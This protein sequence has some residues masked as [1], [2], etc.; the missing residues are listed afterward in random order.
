MTEASA[1]APSTGWLGTFERRAPLVAALV[2]L[3]AGIMTMTSD[4]IGVFNDDGIYLLTAKALAEGNGYVYPHLPG[5]PP[6]IHYPPVW[7]ML[8]A[9][10]WKIAPD[11]PAN[12]GWFKLINP[13]FIAAAAAGAVT[14]GQRLL[15][16]RWWVALL[17]A[18]AATL[19]V[20]VLLLTNLLLSEP[21][22]L[23]ML[24][25]TLWVTERLVREGGARL[26]FGAAALIAFLVLVRT[27]GGVV[28]VAGVLLLA[29]ERRWKELAILAVTTVALLMPWQIFVWRAIPTFPDELLG[30]YGPYLDWVVKG[31]VEGGVAF[32]GAVVAKNIDA[33]WVM[34]GIFTS[35]LWDG[36]IRQVMAALAMLTFLTGLVTLA[37]RGR[38]PVTALALSG[39]L[40][41]AVAWPFWIDRFIWVVWPIL[42]LITLAGACT[43]AERLRAAG[44]P[45]A[46]TVALVALGAL[47]LGHT[48]YNAR[49]LAKG[50]ESSASRDMAGAGIRLVRHVNDDRSLDGQRIAAE[51]APMLAIYTGLEVLPVEILTPQEHVV[52]KTP[53]A[54]TAELERIDR[55]FRPGA[56]VVMRDGPF[57]SALQAA[58]LDSGRTLI[59]V[60]PDGVPVR[61]L[62]VQVP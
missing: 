12:I 61:T 49:G 35:P 31:Y 5:M 23:L 32:L 1:A 14:V 13:I 39:Y 40:A 22:F 46:A 52:D 24:F 25:P 11:F 9:A 26:A 53:A 60:S 21:L 19:T 18:I 3:V 36:A 2:A 29:R 7:P 47:A 55:R 42:V 6:A 15:G 33:T 45:R 16:L 28:L 27:L 8:L 43:V 59:D 51:L 50:W 17:G 10:V 37:P 20:P 58:R 62:K 54:H 4:P 57:Y 41:V 30:S 56:Y 44:R 38:A 48:T 34:L